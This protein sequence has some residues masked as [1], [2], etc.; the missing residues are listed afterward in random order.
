MTSQHLGGVFFAYIVSCL[1]RNIHVSFIYLQF[2]T[3]MLPVPMY[4]RP[5][6]AQDPGHNERRS[7]VIDTYHYQCV[8][9]L[10]VISARLICQCKERSGGKNRYPSMAANPSL[11]WNCFDVRSLVLIKAE[12]K[13]SQDTVD[14]D[15]LPN[16]HTHITADLQCKSVATPAK[17]QM[18]HASRPPYTRLPCARCAACSF[19]TAPKHPHPSAPAS[20][21]RYTPA[22]FPA[23]H[24]RVPSN[25]RRWE[26]C[27]L[28]AIFSDDDMPPVWSARVWTDPFWTLEVGSY[29]VAA[30]AASAETEVR[31]R[32]VGICREDVIFVVRWS[33]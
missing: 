32:R 25:W 5:A 31:V 4:V 16:P 11:R 33:E 10:D 8:L 19:E 15:G 7:E 22:R 18:H 24:Q 21:S 17:M 9:H 23:T 14:E 13:P 3:Q 26:V 12:H 30:V 27:S 1:L 6:G 29:E 28:T 20:F 2:Y